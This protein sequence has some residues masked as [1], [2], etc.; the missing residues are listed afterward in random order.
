MKDLFLELFL[1]AVDKD[2]F[3]AYRGRLEEGSIC[4]WNPTLCISSQIETWKFVAHFFYFYFLGDGSMVCNE[5][6]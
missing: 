3:A 5:K 6:F 2:T 1:L 4:Y